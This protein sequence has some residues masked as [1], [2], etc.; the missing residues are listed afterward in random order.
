MRDTLATVKNTARFTDEI[1]TI[2]AICAIISWSCG[3][4]SFDE[5]AKLKLEGK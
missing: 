3:H 5:K 2:V 1:A 4:P